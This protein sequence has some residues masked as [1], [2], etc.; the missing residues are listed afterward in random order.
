MP[1]QPDD[2]AHRKFGQPMAFSQLF[3]R[4]ALLTS[5][6]NL[7]VPRRILL[8]VLHW[9]ALAFDSR[10]GIPCFVGQYHWY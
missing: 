7:A 6:K 10:A 8:K 2:L 1:L 9:G 4:L 5:G 3:N